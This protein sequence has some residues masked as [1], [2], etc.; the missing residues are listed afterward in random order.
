MLSKRWTVDE[1][2]AIV[3]RDM[4]GR[5][6]AQLEIRCSVSFTQNYFDKFFSLCRQE[7]RKPV[8]RRLFEFVRSI[9]EEE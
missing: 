7:K 5:D 2:M 4:L 9:Q 3:T 6:K 1:F 8:H